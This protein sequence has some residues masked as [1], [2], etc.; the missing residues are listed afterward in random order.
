MH[1][2]GLVVDVPAILPLV[3]HGKL[4]RRG[5]PCPLSELVLCDIILLAVCFLEGLFTLP[6]DTVVRGVLRRFGRIR[7][8]FGRG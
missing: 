7:I 3:L 2:R 4:A 8:P 6:L 1:R 5:G